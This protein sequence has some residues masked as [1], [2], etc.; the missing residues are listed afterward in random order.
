M[1]KS[2]DCTIKPLTALALCALLQAGCIRES[3]SAGG[4]ISAAKPLP[5][6]IS[7][8]QKLLLAAPETTAE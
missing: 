3:S 6:E 2:K 8:K 5:D 1:M 7:I 4:E